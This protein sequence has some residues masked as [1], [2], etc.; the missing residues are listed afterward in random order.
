MPHLFLFFLNNDNN[1]VLTSYE[2][3]SDINKD[4]FKNDNKDLVMD[5]TKLLKSEKFT[6]MTYIEKDG[7]FSG[8][9]IS[10]FG[11]GIT[12]ELKESTSSDKLVVSEIFKRNGKATFGFEE[13]LVY[14]R[15]ATKLR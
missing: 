8:E 4:E 9:C 7:V 5:Y 13:P 14:K 15:I 11:P 2:I 6:P 1:V 10:T 12:F 3:P